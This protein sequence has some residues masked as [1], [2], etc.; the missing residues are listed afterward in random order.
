[1]QAQVI[2]LVDSTH[3]ALTDQFNDLV[4]VAKD[5]ADR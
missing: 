2:R 3:A 4:S 1:V 5:R